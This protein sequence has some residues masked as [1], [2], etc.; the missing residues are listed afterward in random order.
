MVSSPRSEFARTARYLPVLR[1][2]VETYFAF[3]A[4]DTAAVRREGLTSSQFDVVATLGNTSGMTCGELSRRTLV[5]KG[6]LTGVLDRLEGKGVVAREPSREDRRSIHVR[7]TR[8]G[9]RLFQRSFPAVVAAIS[10]Y[11][12]RAL[13]EAEL[14]TLRRLLLRL[15]RSLETSLTRGKS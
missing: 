15:K 1:A 9:E 7:L 14:G 5:T 2:L 10:P 3:L 6:T 12:E 8:K 4:R 11:F 13:N